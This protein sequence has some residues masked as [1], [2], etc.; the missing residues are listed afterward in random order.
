[1]R[2][3][4]R[5]VQRRLA[6][7]RHVA[8]VTGNVAKTCRYYGISRN[9]YYTWFRRH[10]ESGLEGLRDRSRRP[11]SHPRATPWEVVEKVLYLRRYYHFGPGRIQMYLHRYHAITMSKTG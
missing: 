4:D 2:L 3:D 8:E 11:R 9:T 6:W 7:F 5:M 1:M 10:Q